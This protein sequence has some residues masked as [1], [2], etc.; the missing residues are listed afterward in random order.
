LPLLGFLVSFLP[1]IVIPRVMFLY[2]YL[3]SLV[4]AVCAVALW[5]D[6][7]GWTPKGGFAEQSRAARWLLVAIPIGFLVISPITYGFALPDNILR[8][9]V[10]LVH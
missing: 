6:R 5:M 4:F 10:Q 9:L 3:P 2:H 7:C 1:F 8:V